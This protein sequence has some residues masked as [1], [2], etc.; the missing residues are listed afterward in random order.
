MS[1]SLESIYNG[2]AWAIAVHS[3]ALAKLQEQAASGQEVNRPSDNPYE[4][5]RILDLRTESRSMERFVNTVSEVV[6]MLEFSGSVMQQMSGEQGLR[7]ALET[8]TSA[9]SPIYSNQSV[10]NQKAS[11]LN[12]ILENMVSLANKQ[13]LG[14]RLFAGADSDADPYQVTRNSAGE[15]I[16]VEYVGSHEEQKVV[17]AP[18]VEVSSVLVGD[19]LFRAD[20]VGTPEFYGSTNAKAGS[21]TSSVRGDVEL[22]ITGTAGAW[23]LSIDGGATTFT[24]DGSDANLPVVNGTTGEVLYV[25]TTD[26]NLQAGTAYVRVP[27]TYDLFNILINTRDLLK[28]ESNM[29]ETIWSQYIDKTITA[30]QEVDAKLT[31]A[32]PIIGGRITTLTNL[33]KSLEDIKMNA[34][35]EISRRQDADITQ[36]ALNLSRHEVLY[37]MS[38]AVS[39]KMFSLSLTDFIA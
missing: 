3:S 1:F 24:S 32:Y 34:E 25:D 8:L 18:G 38:L 16:R 7:G 13:R 31:R 35:E 19:E 10:R 9:L 29:P 11:Q 22:T 6:G 5:N 39:A 14:Q 15:I 2:A 17:V 33:Q 36:V 28:N 27:G 37:E 23:V 4:A 26:A 20:D 30:M 21:G 12:E